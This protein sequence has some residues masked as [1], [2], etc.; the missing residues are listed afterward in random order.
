MVNPI[1]SQWMSVSGLNGTPVL[2]RAGVAVS[3][4]TVRRNRLPL[5]TKGHLPDLELIVPLGH[6]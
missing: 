3:S 6:N 5:A 4:R 1:S 2:A